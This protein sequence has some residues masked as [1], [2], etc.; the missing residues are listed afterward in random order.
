MLLAEDH[1]AMRLGTKH[2]LEQE[3][4]LQV[5]GEAGDGAEHSRS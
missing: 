3:Q 4:D 1:A 2:I 5:V